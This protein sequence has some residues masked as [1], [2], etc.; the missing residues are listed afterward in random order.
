MLVINCFEKF[1]R[2]C[3]SFLL[4]RCPSWPCGCQHQRR[5]LCPLVLCAH[6]TV[7]QPAVCPH[8]HCVTASGTLV[9]RAGRNRQRASGPAGP[10]LSHFQPCLENLLRR[11]RWFLHRL[12]LSFL[13]LG[14][15]RALCFPET[16]STCP[17]G[18]CQTWF[19]S[20]TL[21]DPACLGLQREPSPPPGSHGG[22]GDTICL[23]LSCAAFSYCGMTLGMFLVEEKTMKA[24]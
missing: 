10:S 5:N 19:P 3:P 16:L 18:T 22:P 14:F 13:P 11:P 23:S 4:F 17:D 9:A 2:S 6:R 24:P 21:V 20:Q 12:F 8:F 1:P 7:G 15:P